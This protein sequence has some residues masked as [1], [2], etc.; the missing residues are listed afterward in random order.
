MC[1]CRKHVLDTIPW[2]VCCS[3]MFC[4]SLQKSVCDVSRCVVSDLGQVDPIRFHEEDRQLPFPDQWVHDFHTFWYFMGR[5]LFCWQ[6]CGDIQYIG[7]NWCSPF[8]IPAAV[9]EVLVVMTCHVCVW[10]FSGWW[11]YSCARQCV[12]RMWRLQT[13][14]YPLGLIGLAA[15][16]RTSLKSISEN[17]AQHSR[18][19]SCD[20]MYFCNLL[21][22]WGCW[23]V[24]TDHHIA[25][26]LETCSQSVWSPL[27]PLQRHI[28]NVRSL[29]VSSEKCS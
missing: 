27:L 3:G 1:V 5:T 21:V 25:V 9:A 6:A 16:K 23:I 20:Q 2:I 10:M 15:L 28:H 14:P 4:K 12:W 18:S 7:S 19:W 29:Q 13:S 24:W 8:N 11:M 22:Q 26:A 17:K